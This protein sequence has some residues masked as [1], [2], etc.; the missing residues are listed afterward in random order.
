MQQEDQNRYG[1]E[2]LD[3]AQLFGKDWPGEEVCANDKKTTVLL[4]FC[5]INICKM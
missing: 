2:A 3:E 4:V 1:D 5:K